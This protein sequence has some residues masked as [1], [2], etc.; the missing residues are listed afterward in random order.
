MPALLPGPHGR[1]R[2]LVSFI[3]AWAIALPVAAQQHVHGRM[4]LDVAV[5]AQSITLAI[6]APL[7]GF[8]GLERAPRSDSERKRAADMVARLKAADQLFQPDPAAG[9]KLSK[10]DLDSA[11][12]GLGDAGKKAG[13]EQEHGHAGKAAHAGSE[14]ADIDVDIVFNCANAAAARFIDVRLFD[15]F[16][17]IRTIDAQVAAPQGQFKRT[18]RPGAPRL[19]LVR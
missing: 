15:A 19:S 2:A 18:L 4:A 12:L 11:V 17:R 1:A 10:V 16:S 5:D 6:D 9:C 13:R 8:L 3:G 14:H 7:D